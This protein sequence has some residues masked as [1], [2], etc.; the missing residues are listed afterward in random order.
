VDFKGKLKP[1]EMTMQVYIYMLYLSL[2]SMD[3][4]AV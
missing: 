2:E 1:I 3:L 4:T